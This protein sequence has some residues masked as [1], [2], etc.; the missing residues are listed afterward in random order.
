MDFASM[1]GVMKLAATQ[2]CILYIMVAVGFITDRI[3]LFT[4]KTALK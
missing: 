2:V 1:A 4:E 3:G